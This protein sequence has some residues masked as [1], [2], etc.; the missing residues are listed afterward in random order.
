M[1]EKIFIADIPVHLFTVELLHDTLRDSIQKENKKIFLHA[2]ARLIELANTKSKWLVEFFNQDNCYVICDGAGVQLAAK[3]SGQPIPQK[4]P[5][6]LWVW[7]LIE[8][9]SDNNFSIY[10]LGSTETNILNASLNLKKRQ[11]K[12]RIAGHHHGFFNKDDSSEENAEIINEINRLKPDVLMVGFGMPFQEK[13]I[14]ENYHRIDSF[15]MLTCGGAFDFISGK[16]RVAPYFFRKFCLEWLFRFAM[17]PIRLFSRAI[18]S[19]FKFLKII[20]RK[21]RNKGYGQ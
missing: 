15:A 4:I 20:V 2:N 10:L 9:L 5:Y 8:F 19:N 14:R 6:N 1:T 21:K 12:L 16:K 11:P 3:L 13:W 7:G 18:I 17:E